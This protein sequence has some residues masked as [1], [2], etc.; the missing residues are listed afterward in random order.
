MDKFSAY[1]K[2]NKIKIAG[3]VSDRAS[4]LIKLGSKT[5]L[6]VC[7]MP[8]LFHFM[9]DIGKLGGL[10]IGKKYKKAKA[11][12]AKLRLKQKTEELSESEQDSIKNADEIIEVYG[13]YRKETRLINQTIH[14]FN[15]LNEWTESTILRKNL[16]QSICKI[17]QFTERLGAT[18]DT[19][20]ATKIV[21]QIPD[22]V[23]GVENWVKNNQKKIN[24][25]VANKVITEVEKIWFGSFLLPMVYWQLQLQRTKN[26][27]TN[28]ELVAYYQNQ[29][30]ECQSKVLE[31]LQQEEISETRQEVLFEMAYQ[32][33]KSFQRSSSQV[34]GR[35]GH[36]AFMHHGQKGISEIR[37][38]ALTVIYNFDTRRND[39]STPA[40]RLFRKDFPDLFEF[41]C[42]NVTG[43]KE[44]RKRKVKPSKRKGLQR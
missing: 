16:L 35:N 39:G 19:A 9:Q 18:V 12:I 3:I 30:E 34:E 22:I 44:P 25:W 10:Q 31:Y 17:G 6:N 41:L 5:Y 2:I 29:I 43:F 27:R 42:Q 1:F 14:P 15:D 20:K 33:A 40:Q 8:D 24:D 36:L 38:K 7:S 23:K 32:M 13:E 26:G 4:A 21:R 37:K 28:P 11:V